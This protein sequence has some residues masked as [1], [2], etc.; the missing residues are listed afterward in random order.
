MMEGT[1]AF[2]IAV[3]LFLPMPICLTYS[4][5]GEDR[6]T[7]PPWLWRAVRKDRPP[8]MFQAPEQGDG[9]I[10]FVLQII[11][12]G[13][14]CAIM[15]VAISARGLLMSPGPDALPVLGNVA[16]YVLLSLEMLSRMMWLN[17]HPPPS[18]LFPRTKHIDQSDGISYDCPDMPPSSTCAGRLAWSV[19]P[20]F[21]FQNRAHPSRSNSHINASLILAPEIDLCFF[22]RLCY[23]FICPSWHLSNSPSHN[24]YVWVRFLPSLLYCHFVWHK[25]VLHIQKF[26]I[27]LKRGLFM[28]LVHVGWTEAKKNLCPPGL[29]IFQGMSKIRHGRSHKKQQQTNNQRGKSNSWSLEQERF[30]RVLKVIPAPDEDAETPHGTKQLF[31]CYRK[32]AVGTEV[33]GLGFYCNLHQPKKRAEYKH[34]VC[35]FPTR[36]FEQ[37]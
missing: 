5:R 4:L 24:K 17:Q 27:K 29:F 14:F 6:E 1:I 11:P 7:S 35:L 9:T 30:Q 25:T 21:A 34:I 18:H 28:H 15:S 26:F 16:I 22:L 13:H 20:L 10:A 8:H 33:L 23:H 36:L 32:R 3:L 31:S 37:K 19:F 12:C 2:L